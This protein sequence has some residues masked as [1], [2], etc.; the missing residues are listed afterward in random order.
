MVVAVLEM[1]ALSSA[2]VAAAT[3]AAAPLLHCAS[4]RRRRPKEAPAAPA[5]RTPAPPTAHY[6]RK[7]AKQRHACPPSSRAGDVMGRGAGMSHFGLAL[8]FY[9]H[10]TSPIRRYADVVA[11]RQLLAAVAAGGHL[12]RGA[13]LAPPPDLAVALQ[14]VGRPC[15]RSAASGGHARTR[16]PGASG[17][18]S[19]TGHTHACM[20]ACTFSSWHQASLHL[21]THTHTRFTQTTHPTPP[22]N[23]HPPARSNHP[24][25][26]TT[27]PAPPRRRRPRR[28]CPPARSPRVRRS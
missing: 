16:A 20:H 21:A 12:L 7:G 9:T 22:A 5:L 24:T 2:L 1:L 27:P 26:H 15:Q 23:P 10:F 6:I 25:P 17:W 28:R 3:V 8:P 11:H 14:Q 13:D 19:F 4:C 18:L